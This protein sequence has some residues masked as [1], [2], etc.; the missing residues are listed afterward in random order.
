[1]FETIELSNGATVAGEQHPFSGS[2]S[3]MIDCD[4]RSP[5]ARATIGRHRL[6]HEQLEMAQGAMFDRRNGVAQDDCGLHGGGGDQGDDWK[7]RGMQRLLA[8][9]LTAEDE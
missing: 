5:I 8:M 3:Q 7:K 1:M 9:G 2:R 6:A 4:H